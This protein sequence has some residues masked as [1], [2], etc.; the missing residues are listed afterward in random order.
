[1]SDLE[2]SLALVRSRSSSD[3]L[4]NQKEQLPHQHLVA[5]EWFQLH[6][7]DIFL[8]TTWFAGKA[9]QQRLA[10]KAKGIYKPQGWQ[11]A[12]SI[13][14][15]DDGPY[16]DGTINYRADGTWSFVYEAE[17][18]GESVFTNRALMKNLENEVPIGVYM[19][20]K[21][22]N[23]SV[24]YE[25]G[26]L[27]LP[28]AFSNGQFLIEG[29]YVLGT[30]IGNGAVELS[31]DIAKRRV[32]REIVQR[33]GQGV[34]RKRL[35]QAYGS[36]CAVTTYDV[37]PA[38]EAAHIRPYSGPFSNDV[39]NGILLRADIHTLFDLR[40]VGIHP[41]TRSLVIGREMMHSKYAPLHGVTIASPSVEAFRP[42]KEFLQYAWNEFQVRNS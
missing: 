16:R 5:L 21:P 17:I 25:I 31:L 7:G 39:G 32:V 24:E 18:G 38:I 42:K 20:T 11:Y 22:T 40:H 33:Q 29:P 26:G 23:S 1:M 14:K 35:L 27:G 3:N 37:A 30:Q 36:R 19:K 28:T 15:S 41:E 9:I 4:R 12:L 10:G 6:L 8:D 34:F 13:R 2:N